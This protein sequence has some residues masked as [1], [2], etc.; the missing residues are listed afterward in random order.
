MNETKTLY[1]ILADFQQWRRSLNLSSKTM[2]KNQYGLQYF[3]KWLAETYR[4]E[5]A[6]RIRKAHLYAWQ[7]HVAGMTNQQGMPLKPRSI[8]NHLESVKTFLS[9]LFSLG[10]INKSY[11]DVLQ[12]V[13]VP[14]HL[15]GNILEHALMRKVLASIPTGDTLGYRNRAMMEL[16]YSAGIRVSELLDLNVEDLDMRNAVATVTGK[17]DK[18]RVVPIGR[19]ALRHM[20]TYIV[21]VRPYLLKNRSEKAVFLS[22]QGKR[23][24]YRGFLR[25]VHKCGEQAGVEGVLTPHTFRRS[26]TT[27]LIRGDANIY[28]VKELLGH[29]SLDTLKHYAK[30]TITDLKKTHAKCHPREQDQA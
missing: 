1:I 15:P 13:K 3:I 26:C 23:L 16:L 20:E 28:H 22:K 12:Y 27:E 2:Q 5:T 19:T 21:A 14:Q 18:Q 24:G 8:N 17:G 6:D 9:Y 29:E 25:F 10:Y 11:M 4:V 7:E 30:L